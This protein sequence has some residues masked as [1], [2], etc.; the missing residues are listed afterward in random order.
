MKIS[1]VIPVYARQ[2]TGVRAIRSVLA[3]SEPIFEIVVVDDGS[4]EPFFLPD[5]LA[6]NSKIRLIRQD[7]AGASAARNRGVSEARGDYVAFLD[8]DDYW[9]P[10]K[11]AAQIETVRKADMVRDISPLVFV[12]GF[13][14]INASNGLSRDR[15]PLESQDVVDFAAGCWFAPG[16]TA[17]FSKAVFDLVG[18]FDEALPRLED[19][20][21]YLRLARNGGGI[22]VTPDILSVVEVGGKPSPRVLAASITVLQ[23]K[24]IAP[25]AVQR[26]SDTARRNLLAYCDLEWASVMWANKCNLAMVLALT[27]SLLRRPR[28]RLHLREWWRGP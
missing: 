18:A 16:S 27:R 10:G 6:S 14:Q 2:A 11:I 25:A 7:N 15:I 19:L 4:P 5:D 1:A 24:W 12:T 26:L 21:W 23:Q 9:L 20:D 8:S 13:R 17:L 28:Q 3:Q 22:V